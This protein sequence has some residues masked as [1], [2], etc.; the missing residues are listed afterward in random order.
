MELKSNSHILIFYCLA[1]KR[2]FLLV[3]PSIRLGGL[4]DRTRCIA[5]KLK[6]P[7][8]SEGR[9]EGCGT[10]SSISNQSNEKMPSQQAQSNFQIFIFLFY[11]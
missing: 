4:R 2:V 8:Q 6:R 5:Y 10:M 9:I 11:Q 7:E 3:R 1:P